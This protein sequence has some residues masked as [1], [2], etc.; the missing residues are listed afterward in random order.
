MRDHTQHEAKR[1]MNNAIQVPED[2]GDI[3]HVDGTRESSSSSLS[4]RN[5]VPPS[6]GKGRRY[7]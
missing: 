2:E 6:S 7:T 5:P 4:F 3:R 1:T